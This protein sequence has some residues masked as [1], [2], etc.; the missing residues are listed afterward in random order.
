MTTENGAGDD[1]G[2][3]APNEVPGLPAPVVPSSISP[4]STVPSS[5]ALVLASPAAQ[6]SAPGGRRPDWLVGQ[7][8]VGMLDD[9]FFYRF[10]CIF[11]QQAGTYL[12]DIDNLS[13]TIDPAVAPPPMVQ[14]MAAW[15][16]LPALNPSL[17]ETYQRHFVQDSSKLM[18]WRGTRLGLKGML[19][20]I[21]GGRVEVDD[22]GGVFREGEGGQR[23]PEVTIRVETTGWVPEATFLEFVRDEVPANVRVALV[24]GEREVWSLDAGEEG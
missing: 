17:D 10:V 1:G 6:A 18:R 5:T 2:G 12:D 11:Q 22:S 16:A 23:P 21:T 19:E 15:L 20:L 8:P 7:L 13:N 3:G 4:S 14:F 24:I 9:D